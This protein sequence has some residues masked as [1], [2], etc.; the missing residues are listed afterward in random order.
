MVLNNP[1]A[2][3]ARMRA[4]KLSAALVIGSPLRWRGLPAGRDEFGE[5]PE[6]LSGGCQVEFVAGAASAAP[7]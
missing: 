1:A 3:V 2:N 7:R 6:V 4:V 5:F